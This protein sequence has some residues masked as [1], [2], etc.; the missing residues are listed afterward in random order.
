M[1]NWQSNIDSSVTVW[2][3]GGGPLYF[4]YRISVVIEH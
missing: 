3:G 2:G 4:M 1:N